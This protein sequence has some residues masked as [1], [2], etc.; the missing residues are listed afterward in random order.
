MYVTVDI[1]NAPVRFIYMYNL[2][3]IYLIK[4]NLTYRAVAGF[5]RV[6]VYSQAILRHPSLLKS[7][8]TKLEHCLFI[9][10]TQIHF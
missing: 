8:T 3:T 2:C 7:V 6:Y 9:R 1:Q 5:N 4:P 10:V